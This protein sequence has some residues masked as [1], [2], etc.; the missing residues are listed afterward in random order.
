MRPLII[1][2]VTRNIGSSLANDGVS[3]EYNDAL[4]SLVTP[5]LQAALDE[6]ISGFKANTLDLGDMDNFKLET[7][8]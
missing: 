7:T 1:H 8:E 4:K 5:E 3:V 6:A 2:L